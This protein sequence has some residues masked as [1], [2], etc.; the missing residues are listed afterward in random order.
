MK[1]AKSIMSWPAAGLITVLLLSLVGCQSTPPP[2]PVSMI[3]E[4]GKTHVVRRG[5]TL[6]AIAW[7][8]GLDYRALARSN[9]ISKP[10][11]IYVG[12]RLR[13]AS[14][15]K[16]AKQS[17]K[18]AATP[19]VAKTPARAVYKE[20]PVSKPAPPPLLVVCLGS[21]PL[22]VKSL[23][24]SVYRARSTRGSMF[25]RQPVMLSLRLRMVQSFMQGVIFGAMESWLSLKHDAT[26]LSAYGNNEALTVKEGDTVTKGQEIGRLGGI[27][28]CISKFVEMAD[29]R[30]LSSTYLRVRS[31]DRSGGRLAF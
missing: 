1:G 5:E 4:R 15:G 19:R 12:Q 11:T 27:R 13:L 29:P 6:Y 8:Y 25:E 31:D 30:I 2:A 17:T 21:G 14:T 23:R 10:Y 26:F 9:G 20:K 3:G 22:K 16:S 18:G 7:R 24:S 28:C